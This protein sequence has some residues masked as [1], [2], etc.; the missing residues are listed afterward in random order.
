MKYFFIILFLAV[1][2]LLGRRD[3][4]VAIEWNTHSVN[5]E[6]GLFSSGNSWHVSPWL[7]AY[8]QT[9]EWWVFHCDKGWL[10]PESDG[11][12][13]VW[14]Y[15]NKESSW[16]WTKEGVYPYAWHAS[17]EAWF[18]FCVKPTVVAVK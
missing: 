10:Y 1:S 18:N 17:K 8:Y 4:H 15:W 11:N 12:R 5:L 7:G 6:Q 3:R 2:P 14:L 13:G 9:Q 16:V